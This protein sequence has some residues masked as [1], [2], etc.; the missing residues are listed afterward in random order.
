MSEIGL[1]GAPGTVETPQL[2]PIRSEIVV[3]DWSLQVLVAAVNHLDHN[4][5]VFPVTLLSGGIRIAGWLVRQEA[6]F[7]GSA[8]VLKAEMASDEQGS[9]TID[10]MFTQ[11]SDQIVAMR[12]RIAQSDPRSAIPQYVHLKDVRFFPGIPGSVQPWLRLRLESVD[13]FAFGH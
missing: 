3:T 10:H 5:P 4:G 6:F 8:A 1:P 7:D 13:G 12:A 9:R 11:F 2:A